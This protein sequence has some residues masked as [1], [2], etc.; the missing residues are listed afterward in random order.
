MADGTLRLIHHSNF[1]RIYGLDI[2]IEGLAR[3]RDGLRW[4]LDVYGDGPWRGA[5]EQAIERTATADRVTLHGRAS[6]DDLPRLIAGSD[7]GLVPSLSEP[8]LEYSLSTKLLEYA[9]MGVPVVATDLATFR[10]YF[11]D[12]ALCFI[13]GGDPDALARAVEGLADDPA[14]ATAMGAEAQRQAAAY[15][16]ESQKDRYLAVVE[17]LA[18][19]EMAFAFQLGHPSKP[20]VHV[21]LQFLRRHFIHVAAAAKDVEKSIR[22]SAHVCLR[23]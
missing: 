2:A 22:F 23:C 18:P 10:H 16:W 3:V 9:A 8:Y 4:E 21:L 19:F 13:P 1:Q 5:I 14:R 6:M 15:D 12:A 11:S 7:I 17:R 20:R